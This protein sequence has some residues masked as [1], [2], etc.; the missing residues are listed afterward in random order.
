V[1][2]CENPAAQTAHLVFSD[3]QNPTL[4]KPKELFFSNA[5]IKSDGKFVEFRTMC[6]F[7]KNWQLNN[8]K[9]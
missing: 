8:F 7:D 1:P 5:R 4:K 3:T 2:H 6:K 9:I